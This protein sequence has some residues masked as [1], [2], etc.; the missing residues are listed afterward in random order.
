MTRGS[1]VG[2]GLI[3]AAALVLDGCSTQAATPGD[4]LEGLNRG[5]S[6]E[7][8]PH[9]VRAVV[10]RTTGMPETPTIDVV[11]SVHAE[12]E[13]VTRDQFEA[14]TAQTKDLAALAQKV[15]TETAEPVK[16]SMTKVFKKVG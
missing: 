1:L 14:M 13:G 4:P 11:F 10:L 12:G 8:A 9:G 7:I 6:A 15:M 16:D 2:V 3:A 5:L